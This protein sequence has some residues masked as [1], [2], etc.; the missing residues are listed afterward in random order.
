MQLA[1]RMGRTLAELQSSM[2]SQEFSL[3]MQLYRDDQWGDGPANDRADQRAGV[4]AAT[5]A[6][7]AGKQLAKGAK[8]LKASDFFSKPV[9]QD[10][11]KEVD[12]VAFF[13]AVSKNAKFDKKGKRN[14]GS[15]Y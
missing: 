7:F 1:L 2:S 14:A 9:T 6:N 3:W 15:S 13:T 11:P 8:P 10:A 12:P 4:I 5:F